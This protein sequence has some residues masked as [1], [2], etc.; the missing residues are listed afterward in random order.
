MRCSAANWPRPARAN[1]L[2]SPPRPTPSPAIRS[3][4]S[5][6]AAWNLALHPGQ[7]PSGGRR[8]D[9][10]V[11][12]A[13]QRRHSRHRGADQGAQEQ[14]LRGRSAQAAAARQ[15]RRR[16]ARAAGMA[17]SAPTPMPCPPATRR[18]WK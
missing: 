15:G 9:R 11:R 7:Q 4:S 3:P 16:G 12:H 18:P 17:S 13:G 6:P 14:P 5:T 1:P 8:R 10:A 2:P